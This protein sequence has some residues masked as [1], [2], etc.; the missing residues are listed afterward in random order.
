MKQCLLIITIIVISLTSRSQKSNKMLSTKSDRSEY[1]INLSSAR[2]RIE[3][4]IQKHEE[5]RLKELAEFLSIPSISSL[6]AHKKDVE[7]AAE[8]LMTKCRNIGL[9]NSQIINTGGNPIVFAEWNK[10]KGKPTILIYGHYDVQPVNEEE[11]NSKPFVAK[12]EGDNIYARGAADDKGG[13]MIAVWAIETLLKTK[14]NLPVNVKCVFEGGEESGSPGFK[15]FLEENKELLQADFA[16]NADGGQWSETQPNIWIGLRG[17]ATLEFT[18]KTADKDAHSGIYGGKT[19]NAAKAMAEIIS[20]FYNPDGR[21]AVVGFYDKVIPLTAT[22]KEMLKKVPYNAAK[23]MKQLGTTADEGDTAYSPLERIWFRPTLEVN[24][25][26]GG[27]TAKE[28]FATIVPGSA[29]ARISCRL[30]AN[31]DAKEIIAL[32]KKHIEEHRSAGTSISY[33]DSDSGAPPVKFPTDTKAFQSVYD[34]LEEVYRQQ[35]LLT[36][37]GGTI[38]AIADLRKVIGLYVYSFGFIL[39]DENIHAANEFIRLSDI[40]KGQ[41]AYCLLLQYIGDHAD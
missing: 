35:P 14:G 32:I 22:E 4:Y 31:Q 9:T 29:H 3:E 37:L 24:G 10:A 28:G 11:W 26:W 30:V 13:L 38:G 39:D 21:V 34:V 23:D 18:V 17:I 25:L 15:Q 16:Y 7:N 6:P 1:F 41:I 8:W 19:P 5:S 20:S 40:R 12:R 27:Y 36:A 2:Q 33:K